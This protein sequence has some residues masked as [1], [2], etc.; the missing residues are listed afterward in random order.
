M[1][2]PR[3]VLLIVLLAPLVLH[4]QL[5]ARSKLPYLGPYNAECWDLPYYTS[6]WRVL[7]FAKQYEAR[8]IPGAI[9]YWERNGWSQTRVDSLFYLE[10]FK[11]AEGTPGKYAF[12]QDSACASTPAISWLLSQA[13]AEDSL[14]FRLYINASPYAYQYWLQEF[15][16]HPLVHLFERNFIPGQRVADPRLSAH[17]AYQIWYIDL[18][19]GRLWLQIGPRG[20]FNRHTLRVVYAYGSSRPG[21]LSNN[22]EGY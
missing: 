4:A 15:R 21:A 2:K 12:Y 14:G 9:A 16:A 13:P 20:L 22:K 3:L 1:A 19:H 10:Y 17:T 11:Y 5:P 8:G 7:A 18:R 6:L